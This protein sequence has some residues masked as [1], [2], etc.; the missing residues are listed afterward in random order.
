MG[1]HAVEKGPI[2]GA[3]A[4]NVRGVRER[5]GWTQQILAAEMAKVGRSMQSSA[6]AKIESQSRRVDVDDLVALAAALNVPIARLL[7]PDDKNADASV[8]LLPQVRTSVGRAWA[9][10]NGEQA[11]DQMNAP[12]VDTATVDLAYLDERPARLRLEAQA[13]LSQAARHLRLAVGQALA[14]SP[15]FTGDDTTKQTLAVMNEWLAEVDDCIELVRAAS[16]Q[17][18]KQATRLS[19]SLPAKTAYGL[20]H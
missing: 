4:A 3:V 9:W 1:S 20:A 10:L 16:S 13:D 12:G 14:H 15:T 5:R 19:K 17:M 18:T 11:L 8:Q 7:M 2:A 6:V